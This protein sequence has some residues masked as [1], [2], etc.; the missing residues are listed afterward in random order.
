ME[1]PQ[2]LTDSSIVQKF[3]E[4]TYQKGKV[5]S[6]QNRVYDAS[7]SKE[8]IRGSCIGSEN[9]SYQ[10][11]V[12]HKNGII[13]NSNCSCPV[14]QQGKCKHVVA[15]LLQ[16]RR[17]NYGKDQ[18][19][20][21]SQRSSSPN[22]NLPG[23]SLST[24]ESQNTKT[25][26]KTPMKALSPK[27]H[28]TTLLPSPSPSPS[29]PPTTSSS[30][31]SSK[32]KIEETKI[33]ETT[34]IPQPVEE[35]DLYNVEL[36]KQ[37][38]DKIKS[39]PSLVTACAYRWYIRTLENRIQHL[40]AVSEQKDNIIRELTEKLRS[41]RM[42]A[43][44]VYS[45]PRPYSPNSE[46]K[47]EFE[48]R[49]DV[50]SPTKISK[51]KREDSSDPT[52]ADPFR[53]FVMSAGTS[54]HPAKK[55]KIHHGIRPLDLGVVEKQQ[56]P[57]PNNI[58][59][60]LRF[61][62]DDEI[63]DILKSADAANPSD[64][65]VKSDDM[66]IDSPS[67]DVVV[68]K[69]GSDTKNTL[70]KD[71][72]TPDTT[73]TTT[74]TVETEVKQQPDE[75]KKP[76]NNETP[77]DT[78][79]LVESPLKKE[80]LA[81]ATDESDQQKDH[82]LLASQLIIK[83]EPSATQQPAQSTEKNE[84]DAEIESLNICSPSASA[85]FGVNLEQSA[86]EIAINTAINTAINSAL[87]G[88]LERMKSFMNLEFND[89]ELNEIKQEITGDLTSSQCAAN[90][91]L[92]STALNTALGNAHTSSQIDNTLNSLKQLLIDNQIPL[93][94]ENPSV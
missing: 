62:N 61:E 92:L 29:S 65:P 76:V 60:E 51:R 84:V 71:I 91:E 8:M 48:K 4:N 19:D 41:Y 20:L 32:I 77:T 3:G 90:P 26:K 68:A 83:S 38:I 40:D 54:T 18:V 35:R 24:W 14:G 31:S 34:P 50:Q 49:P 37:S 72:K 47:R 21:S 10:V 58:V 28:K 93:S 57:K 56:K 17:V 7:S 23:F 43:S 79:T 87:D 30:T 74:K 52:K 42:P 69:P 53:N 86:S 80:Q 13:T 2:Y 70:D 94:Q 55:Q 44:P 81:P 33:D 66:V 1:C 63:A 11:T 27:P 85:F 75:E 15:L 46:I 73:S 9:K 5:Y 12:F 82:L 16:W 67:K 64:K 88:G 89:P 6:N 78:T 22:K 59:P 39:L 36:T 25:P 45:P